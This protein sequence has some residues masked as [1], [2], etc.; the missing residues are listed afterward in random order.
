VLSGLDGRDRLFGDAGDDHLDGG[1]Q[2]DRMEGGLGDD[3]YVVDDEGDV[4]KEESDGGF[5]TVFSSIDFALASRLEALVLTGTEDLDG[6]G[7]KNGNL[8]L[9]NSGGNLLSGLK[10]AD[11]IEGGDGEDDI[12]GGA[13]KDRLFGDGGNDTI[14]GDAGADRLSGN[15]GDDVLDGGTGKDV[16]DGGGGADTFVVGPDSG[17]DR[18]ADFE[19]GIDLIDLSATGLAFDDL[20]IHRRGSDRQVVVAGDAVI[21]VRGDHLAPL[22]AAD[23]LF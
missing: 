14:A 11:R 21:D 22:T 6:T 2:G 12:H 3:R 15:G 23:F 16:L 20:E 19:Q 5:D 18:I 1:R 8:I 9:G 4:I 17:R 10:G 13:G 7:N